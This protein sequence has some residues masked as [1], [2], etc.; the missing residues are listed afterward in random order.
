MATSKLPPRLL[1]SSKSNQRLI[2]D[3]EPATQAR[4]LHSK[5][6]WIVL[7][8]LVPCLL[9]TMYYAQYGGFGGRSADSLL[10]SPSYAL[11]MF[12]I[13]LDVVGLVV[14][15]LLLS[16]NLIKAYF[17]KRHKRWGSGFRTKLI[18]AFIGFSLIPTL[19]LAVMA[20]EVINEVMKVWFNN[21]IEVVLKDSEELSRMY[22]E[23][24]MALAVQSARAISREI[25][26][27]D[28]LQPDYRELLIAAVARKRE[29]FN[30]TG[31][32]VF[33]SKLEMLVRMTA[34]EA[35]DRTFRLPVGQL[36]RRAL[37]S[38][39]EVTSVQIA[40]A[41]RLI[42]AAVPVASNTQPGEIDGVVVVNTYVSE[43]ILAKMQGI[44][45]QY[46]D[47]RQMKALENPI[48]VGAYLFVAVVTVLLLFS[49]TWFGFYV[50]RSITVPIQKLAEGTEAVARGDLNVSIQVNA[51][52]EIGTLI[53][54]FNRMTQDLSTSK[55]KLEEANQ[56]LVESNVEV[57]QRRAYT[58]AVVDTIASGVMSIDTRDTITTFNHSAERILGVEGEAVRGHSVFDVCKSHQFT[59]FQEAY[60]RILLDARDTLTLEGQMEVQ[61]KLLTMG[62]NLSRMKNEAGQN[63]GFVF[64]FEDRTELIK[65][66]KTAAWQEVAQRVA[67]E[68]KNPLTPIQLAAQRLRKKYFERSA[69]FKAIF[70]ES[71]N[72]IVNEVGSLKRMVDEFSKFARLPAPHMSKESLHDIID[73]VTAL[74]RGGHHD[75]EFIQDFDFSVPDVNVDREQV[76]RVFVNLFDNAVQAMK[77]KGRIW[78]ATE[79]DWK[80]H[81]VRITVADEGPGIAQEDHGKLFIPY[82]SRKRMGTGLG[83]A[84]VHRIVTDHNGTIQAFNRFPHGASFT[85]EL[86]A[87]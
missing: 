44:A 56:S 48:K 33:S 59:L 24:H 21:Q 19:L 35:T 1:P 4:W 82:F 27:E 38:Q 17:E 3:D 50:A 62:L 14:L 83:L 53:E 20:S 9:L 25:Y 51:T 5:P 85:I 12:L 43:S 77:H 10:P 75:V 2:L 22:H 79:M 40:Q 67:H 69:D 68:I 87:A 7:F 63:L 60:D 15:T 18:A 58:E 31:V 55:V 57:D 28:F 49:A 32:E 13:Y 81:R 23:G 74:Y 76:R 86:P 45:K 70:D 36:V 29:E 11:V 65:A 6:V 8:F 61:G 80:N 30:V 34:P 37:D 84:I 78:V 72:V 73:K 66:Q 71:T 52:D 26:R 54:S 64:V 16:R 39:D 42:R 41:G 47:Y 46:T